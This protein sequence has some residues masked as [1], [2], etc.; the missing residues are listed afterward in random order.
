MTGVQTCALPICITPIYQYLIHMLEEEK[1]YTFNVLFANKTEE[2]ILLR[3][4]LEK[5]AEEKKINL[6][7]TLDSGNPNW[8]GYTGF[9]SE[10]MFK[11]CFPVVSEDTCSVI[12]CIMV[13]W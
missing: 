9:I 5:L 13:I 7:F 4:E 11:E 2:D 10:T 6:K 3:N 1:K 12:V 8:K